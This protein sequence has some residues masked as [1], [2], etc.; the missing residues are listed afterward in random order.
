MMEFVRTWRIRMTEKELINEI[1]EEYKNTYANV[2]Y[3]LVNKIAFLEE[4]NKD[5]NKSI[6]EKKLR[7]AELENGLQEIRKYIENSDAPQNIKESKTFE[8]TMK[9]SYPGG[10]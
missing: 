5:L 7:I 10:F 9:L 6:H 8:M 4:Q 2:L 1:K 3:H